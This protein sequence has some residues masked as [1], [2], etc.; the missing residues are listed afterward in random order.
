MEQNPITPQEQPL[1]PNPPVMPGNPIPVQPM[2]QPGNSAPVQQNANPIPMQQPGNPAPVQQNTNPVQPPPVNTPSAPPPQQPPA[3]TTPWSAAAQRILSLPPI[4]KAEAEGCRHRLEKRWYRRLIELNILL[5]VSVLALVIS[6][7]PEYSKKYDELYDHMLSDITAVLTDDGT[8]SDDEDDEEE[9]DYYEKLADDMP[10]ELE[11]LGYGLLVLIV[12]YLGLYFYFAQARLYSVRITQRNFPEIYAIID[13]YAKRL[14]MKKTPDAYI[15][16]ANGVLN[17]F[18][19]FIFRRQYI[20]I[21]TEIFEAA[22]RE[23][24]DLDSVAFIIAHEISHIYY[25]HATLH[26]N[27]PIWFSMNFPLF[28]AIA[29]RTREYSCDRLAQLLTDSDGIDAMLM[30]LVDRH[31]YKSV[32]KI[33]YLENAVQEGGFFAWFVNLIAT[34]PVPTK[35]IRALTVRRGNGELY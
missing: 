24:R 20:L 21:N 30:L 2:Q 15:Q 3:Y 9:D 5:I 34:H 22:Y 13:S 28:G 4:A 14:G 33:D 17:A 27:V 26:Y 7:I 16:Q 35:R 18:S 10:L 12:G 8:E 6:N 1:P 29:S 11:A 25:G 31:I 23:H 32:D 19:S